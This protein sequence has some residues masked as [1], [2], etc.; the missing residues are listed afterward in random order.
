MSYNP[1]VH[2]KGNNK[3][4][5]K[6]RILHSKMGKRHSDIVKTAGPRGLSIADINSRKVTPY[7][8]RIP[9]FEGDEFGMYYEFVCARN[10]T[11]IV[12]NDKHDKC[13]RVLEGA[14]YI[15]CDNEIRTLYAGQAI[16]LPK[17]TEYELATSGD[18][19][20]EL[21][22]CQGPSYEDTLEQITAPLASG[23]GLL[24]IP[25]EAPSR[26]DRV[27]PEKS[28]RTAERIRADR[29]QRIESRKPVP[30]KTVTNELGQEVPPPSNQKAPLPGQQVTGANLKPVGAG[31]YGK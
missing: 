31:G 12:K 6:Q 25:K 23:P 27:D 8:W 16:S 1:N 14:L 17:G 4:K 29:K 22:V 21:L 20:V 2:G 28:K 13:V 15:T 24:N 11:G 26:E 5:N 10:G 30:K 7:G 3:R 18:M 19:D 9:Y